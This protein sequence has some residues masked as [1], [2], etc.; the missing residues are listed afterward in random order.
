M[1]EKLKEKKATQMLA[2]E[3]LKNP[4]SDIMENVVLLIVP[5]LNPDGNEKFST[6]N[7]TN[8]NGPINGVG[9]RYNGQHLDLNRDAMKLETPEIIG[10]VE[11]ILNY[12]DPAITV[13]L[14]TT[15]GSFHEE[16]IT[17]TW[18]MNPNGDRSLINYMKDDMMPEVHRKLWGKYDVEN[19]FME[20]LLTG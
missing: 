16:P 9:V 8:Q 7:R 12:W 1:P 6:K 10:V 17:Y 4:T 20:N 11:N 18:M 14:H 2:R 5:I 3:L 15:N 19:I 13:D